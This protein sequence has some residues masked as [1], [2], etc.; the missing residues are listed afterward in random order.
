MGF[1]FLR[2]MGLPEGDLSWL[3]DQSWLGGV[4]DFAISSP[5]KTAFWREDQSWTGIWG[6][7]DQKR[8]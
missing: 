8:R 6:G 2:E 4:Q 5:A 1:P 7:W 3:C